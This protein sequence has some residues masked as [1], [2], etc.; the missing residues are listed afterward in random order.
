MPEDGKRYEA[1]DGELYV[2]EIMVR[3]G[4][5]GA[6]DLVVEIV[7]PNTANRDRT[8]RRKLYERQGVP[9]YWIVDPETVSVEDPVSLSTPLMSHQRSSGPP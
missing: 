1:I 2:K 7:S 6:P 9:Q 4:I 3:E 8:I 5:R